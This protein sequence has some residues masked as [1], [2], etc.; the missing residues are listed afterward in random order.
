MKRLILFLI[1]PCL[2]N[3]LLFCNDLS[4][5]FDIAKKEYQNNNYYESIQ[6]LSYLSNELQKE[7]WKEL[8]IKSMTLEKISKFYQEYMKEHYLYKIEN[9]YLDTT[10]VVKSKTG[11]FSD[12]KSLYLIEVSDDTITFDI[13]SKKN[14]RF[15]FMIDFH[16]LEKIID[17]IGNDKTVIANIIFSDIGYCK[18]TTGFFSSDIYY[19]T[20]IQSIEINS[21]GMIEVLE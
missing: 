15:V 11:N 12:N 21:N 5:Y 7:D 9:V 4:N 1:L 13:E 14:D 10:K 17:V 19:F 8:S 3:L 2:L 6:L 18:T 16:L 20:E